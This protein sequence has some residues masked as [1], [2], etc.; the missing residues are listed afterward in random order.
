VGSKGKIGW[1]SHAC[2]CRSVASLLHI[3]GSARPQS[4]GQGFVWGILTV[5]MLLSG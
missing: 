3:L 2:L 4:Q 1:L 5:R